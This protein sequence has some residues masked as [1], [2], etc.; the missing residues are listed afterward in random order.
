MSAWKPDALAS[1]Q[2]SLGDLV[3]VSGF[4]RCDVLAVLSEQIWRRGAHRLPPASV[5]QPS[6][7]RICGIVPLKG[8]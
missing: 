1:N 5:D 7:Y 2:F 8:R 6:H 4:G 3:D